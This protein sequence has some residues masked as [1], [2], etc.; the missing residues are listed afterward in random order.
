M[1]SNRNGVVK[2]LLPVLNLLH[3]NTI[4]IRLVMTILRSYMKITLNID[5]NIGNIVNPQSTE[6]INKVEE[7]LPNF[8]S[9]V[10]KFLSFQRKYDD[11]FRYFKGSVTKLKFPKLRLTTK[12]GPNGPA[13]LTSHLD[14]IALKS[15]ESLYRI[16][17]QWNRLT[18]QLTL[19]LYVDNLYKKCFQM[20]SNR[21]LYHSKVSFSAEAGGKTRIFA[22]VDY[23]TQCSLIGLHNDLMRKLKS[24]SVV[25]ATFDQDLA[26]KGLA[27][28]KRGYASS[29][30]LTG[31]TDRFPVKIISAVLDLIYKHEKNFY[32][33]TIGSL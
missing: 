18:G 33:E 28:R 3:G 27:E 29:M 4:E 15:D 14:A 13:M 30:D 21:T 26:C 25:D 7:I 24:I 11:V 6:S 9:F 31:A 10:T 20:N 1:K 12:T 23:F 17:E 2:I 22:I 16:F 8:I 5:Y 19:S 32:G